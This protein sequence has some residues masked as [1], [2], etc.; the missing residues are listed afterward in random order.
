ML[1]KNCYN[2][3][4]SFDVY[5]YIIPGKLL[6]AQSLVFDFYFD[7]DILRIALGYVKQMFN[8]QPNQEIVMRMTE[9]W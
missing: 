8:V 7:T 9:A 3:S 1:C 5:L 4:R 6:A 2:F